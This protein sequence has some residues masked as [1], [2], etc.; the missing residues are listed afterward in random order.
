MDNYLEAFRC[1]QKA[2]TIGAL[3]GG[4][5]P[6]CV[7]IAIGGVTGRLTS[8]E[9]ERIDQLIDEIATFVL[10]KMA[11]D[12]GKLDSYYPDYL[13]VGRGTGRFLC[14]GA[15]YDPDE[16][17]YFLTP[18]YKAESGEV[19][20]ISLPLVNESTRFSYYIGD[21]SAVPFL[22]DTLPHKTKQ[23]A[24]SWI[25]APRY[26]GNVS[27]VG[28]YARLSVKGLMNGNSSVL[29]RIRARAIEAVL[30]VQQMKTWLAKYQ[31]QEPNRA[32]LNQ[33]DSGLEAGFLE[34][35]RGSLAHYVIVNEKIIKNYQVVTPTCWNCSPR[36]DNGTPGLLEQAL[37]GTPVANESE[38]IEVLRVIH[39]LDPCMACSV[40]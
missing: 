17:Q 26:L 4:K 8:E 33:P 40:H 27:E 7:G 35:P 32:L 28:P 6:H 22:G 9:I 14:F 5:M 21:K 37:I 18:G 11:P 13:E 23:G 10:G 1:R 19:F 24:Y 36:D 38:P 39:S 15:F 25:K 2:H 12:V 3:I 31:S 29:G 30:L 34:A 20:P 16:E